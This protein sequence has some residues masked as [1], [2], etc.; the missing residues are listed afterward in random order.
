MTQ[1]SDE[2]VFS[3]RTGI[4]PGCR[5]GCEPVAGNFMVGMASVAAGQEDIDVEEVHA[6]TGKESGALESDSKFLTQIINR[7]IG[8]GVGLGF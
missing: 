6:M 8:D 7:L 1:D 3:Q 2:P 5:G 4:P